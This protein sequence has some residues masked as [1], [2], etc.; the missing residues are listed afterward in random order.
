MT[1]AS[2]IFKMFQQFLHGLLFRNFTISH[3]GVFSGTVELL[4]IVQTSLSTLIGVNSIEC[5]PRDPA[6]LPSDI[7]PTNPRTNSPKSKLPSLL[8]STISQTFANS[9][10]SSSSLKSLRARLISSG[11]R[12][13]SPEVSNCLNFR[14]RF[15]SVL[16]P[17]D[18]N[19]F[20]IASCTLDKVSYSLASSS[21]R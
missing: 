20:F 4:H 21:F 10:S 5:F 11:L 1:F 15:V 19:L 7:S 8:R 14:H 16:E 17:R 9:C 18:F 13:P 12:A 2:R 3:T 6:F